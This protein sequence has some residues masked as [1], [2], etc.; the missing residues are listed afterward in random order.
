MKKKNIIILSIIIVMVLCSTSFFVFRSWL[1]Y[2]F[3]DTQCSYQIVKTIY[4]DDEKYKIVAFISNC[5]ATTDFV[6]IVTILEKNMNLKN[7]NN[8]TIFAGRGEWE[9]DINWA[10]KN[11]VITTNC[12]KENIRFQKDELKGIRIKYILPPNNKNSGFY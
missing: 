6:T 3:S 5:G 9:I 2:I 10:N 4:T 1:W 7:S 12:P 8:G 11:L